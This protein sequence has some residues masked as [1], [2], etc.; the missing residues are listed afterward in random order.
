MLSDRTSSGLLDLG[1]DDEM[2]GGMSLVVQIVMGVTL[3]LCSVTVLKIVVGVA[4][5]LCL[6]M[7]VIKVDVDLEGRMSS[8]E[9]VDTVLRIV[10][11]E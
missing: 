6:V 9:M 3:D 2:A 10:V 5:D 4:L 7:V 1:G 11:V 8:S